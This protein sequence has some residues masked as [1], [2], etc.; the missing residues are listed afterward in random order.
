[1]QQRLRTL[2]QLCLLGM[3]H[4]ILKVS[5][6]LLIPC[7]LHKTE[8]AEVQT[9]GVSAGALRVEGVGIIRYRIINTRHLPDKD[10]RHGAI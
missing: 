4:A 3:S 8:L 10:A 6:F 9:R 2:D 7:T 1:M 5:G